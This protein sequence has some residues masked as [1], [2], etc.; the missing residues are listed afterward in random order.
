M[1]QRLS[2]VL[3]VIIL[4]AL[5]AGC[6]RLQ[7]ASSS[8]QYSG[9]MTGQQLLIDAKKGKL[10]S[11]PRIV[12]NAEDLDVFPVLKA[13]LCG[14]GRELSVC[15]DGQSQPLFSTQKEDYESS[16]LVEYDVQ[17]IQQHGN[18]CV[19][20]VIK[21][22]SKGEL[23]EKNSASVLRFCKGIG[24][25]VFADFP[26]VDVGAKFGDDGLLGRSGEVY[27]LETSQGAFFDCELKS[28]TPFS[29]SIICPETYPTSNRSANMVP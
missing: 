5:V 18:E 4:L 19:E 12:P 7:S 15:F 24:L 28:I 11:R 17:K 29:A 22:K 21:S 23:G 16:T 9:I 26:D 14:R 27:V 8:S 6:S 10:Q 20:I 1:K 2:T 13:G 25:V 3:S